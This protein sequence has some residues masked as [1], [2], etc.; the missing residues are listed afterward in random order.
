MIGKWIT[1][2]GIIKNNFGQLHTQ[3]FKARKKEIVRLKFNKKKSKESQK[4]LMSSHWKRKLTWRK[5]L[6]TY[7][8]H[9][10]IMLFFKLIGYHL[11]RRMGEGWWGLFETGRFTT[12]AKYFI[13]CYILAPG[14]LQNTSGSLLTIN[15]YLRVN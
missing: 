8:S 6:I 11:E 13:F 1:K 14:L 9:P 4:K 7:N 5:D 15:I 3:E 12:I 10:W 2:I